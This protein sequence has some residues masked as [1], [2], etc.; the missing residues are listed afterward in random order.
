MCCEAYY[1]DL[2]GPLPRCIA[3]SFR[4]GNYSCNLIC[5]L[6]I[7]VVGLL[8]ITAINMFTLFSKTNVTTVAVIRQ[9]MHQRY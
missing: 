6:P 5:G 4:N 8:L 3:D 2:R 9:T 1:R 7:D